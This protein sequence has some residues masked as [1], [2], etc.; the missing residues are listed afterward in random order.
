MHR[1]AAVVID[2]ARIAAVRAAAELPRAMPVR[3]LPD[4]AWLAPGFI[5]VQVNGGGDVL[6]NDTPTADG[7]RAIAAAHR[8]FG[9]TALLPTLITD[10]PEKMRAALAA[11]AELV[12]RE[13]GILGIHLEGPFLSPERARRACA[14]PYPRADR[15]G[16]HAMLAAPRRA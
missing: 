10:T 3:T 13:P 4:G 14:A 2:G 12:D 15:G 6:F 7:I 8:K 5:D 16:R 11:V 9:T 1:N